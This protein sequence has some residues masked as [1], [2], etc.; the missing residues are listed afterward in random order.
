L[1]ELFSKKQ[2]LSFKESTAK[3]NIWQGAV[4]SGKTYISLWRFLKEIL[5]KKDEEGDFLLLA[6]TYDSIKRNILPLLNSLVGSDCKHFFGKRE[7]HIWGRVVHLIGCDDERAESK[8]RGMTAL[9]AYVDEATILPE[10]V[11]KMLVSRC[12]MGS[13]R[14]F[15]TTNPDSPFHWLKRDFIDD[16]ADVKT[17]LF[18]LDDNP[19]VT[20]ETKEYLKRQYKGLWYQRFI[21]GN[22]VQASGAIYDFF[23]T[24]LHVI[25]ESP[26]GADYS[27]VG[28]DYGTTNPTA[29]ILVSYYGD[30]YPKIVIEKEYYWDSKEKM[31]QKTDAEYADDLKNF[32]IGKK[33]NGIYLDPSATSFRT[34]CI[35]QRM[36]PRYA[37]NEVMEGI[38]FVANT[39]QIGMV[40]IHRN[41]QRLIKSIQSYVWDSKSTISG[42]DRPLKVDDH[43]C[44]ALRYA[45]FSHF[46]KRA[47]TEKVDWDKAYT[48]AMGIDMTF[49]PVFTSPNINEYQGIY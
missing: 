39:L 6:R 28:I 45:I 4:R 25:D 23:D 34:E 1:Q 21:L 36:I 46:Y 14:I 38:R 29:F 37:S 7:I 26:D 11:V 12:A 42:S 40:K 49:P 19:E 48:E 8:L 2:K 22:W 32:I 27:I 33:I 31:R 13:A 3:I 17:W 20:E 24:S 43:L 10:T 15:M 9:G 47:L 18:T 5:E 35:H 44:D 41:C 16:N 30:R